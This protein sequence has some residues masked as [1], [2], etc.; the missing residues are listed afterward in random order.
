MK[1]VKTLVLAVVAVAAIAVGVVGW[2][3][4][5]DLTSAKGADNEALVSAK[6]KRKSK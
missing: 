2:W 4:Y 1:N 3:Q 5:V 6:C